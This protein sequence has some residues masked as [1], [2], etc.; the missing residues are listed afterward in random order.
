[1]TL[2]EHIDGCLN[3]IKEYPE[4]KD[5]PFYIYED[6]YHIEELL[7]TPDVV[8]VSD[9]LTEYLAEEDCFDENDE[10]LQPYNGVLV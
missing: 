7:Y 3:L 1:M 10:L 5:L 9:D 8:I 4:A 6:K 2:Q